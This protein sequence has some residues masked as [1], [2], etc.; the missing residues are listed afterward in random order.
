M[1]PFWAPIRALWEQIRWALDWYLLERVSLWNDEYVTYIHHRP[2]IITQYST[3]STSLFIGQLE[4]F[5]SLNTI[6]YNVLLRV[7]HYLHFYPACV[8]V[9][10]RKN[11]SSTKL[12]LRWKYR[13]DSFSKLVRSESVDVRVEAV[14][15]ANE[16][17]AEQFGRV[18]HSHFW[19]RNSY[20]D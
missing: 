15:Q 7:V 17:H 16:N 6:I 9:T 3:C 12:P 2:R 20:S 19:G 10:L 13:I 5:K 14:G 4:V 1:S 18:G 8:S 11:L